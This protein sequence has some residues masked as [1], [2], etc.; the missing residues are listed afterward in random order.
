MEFLNPGY[1]ILFFSCLKNAL[2]CRSCYTSW[3]TVH[4]LII[5]LFSTSGVFLHKALVSF[6]NG[7]SAGL[8]A[9]S[10]KFWKIR[11]QSW[12]QTGL[13]FLRDLRNLVHV[14]LEEKTTFRS[15]TEYLP[16]Q[17]NCAKRARWRTTSQR[18][19]QYFSPV[20]R[21]LC[22]I[23][24]LLIRACKDREVNKYVKAPKMEAELAS[25]VFWCLIESPHPK[26]N[27]IVKIE[28]ER[29]FNS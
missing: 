11:P 27:I 14:I 22:W 21:K 6:P 7:S 5:R 24:C 16:C 23:A 20:I 9:F 29:A 13:T 19:G 2:V 8:V 25:H 28:I 17:I 12:R 1:I 10:P 4:V 3:Q 26:E 18:Y 15:S